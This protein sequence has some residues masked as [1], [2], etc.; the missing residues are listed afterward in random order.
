VRRALELDPDLAE[1]NT[2]MGSIMFIKYS[3][4]GEAEKYYRRAIALNPNLAEPYARLGMLYNA[5]G[6][7]DDGYAVLTRANELEPTSLNNAIYLG[8]NFCFS[9]QYDRAEA[10]FKRILQFAPNTERAHWFLERIYELTGRYDEAV[11]HGLKEREL[12]RPETVDP[13]LRAYR[14]GGVKS[15]WLKQIEL[16]K[17]ESKSMYGL[18]YRIASRYALAGDAEK[19]CDHVEKNLIDLGSMRNYGRTDP[20]FD[21]LRSKARF[22]KLM[23]DTAPIL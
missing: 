17:E 10:Q 22:I 12:T 16:L 4:W 23:H 2:S 1:A 9:K 14:A 21:P 18:D 5:W 19:A 3:R 13:L 7:F 20:L 8:M 11:V 6:R 15:F